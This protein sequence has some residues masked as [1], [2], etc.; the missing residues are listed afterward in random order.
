MWRASHF[1]RF[2]H[3]LFNTTNL[4][5]SIRFQFLP[6]TNSSLRYDLHTV[7]QKKNSYLSLWFQFPTGQGM[8]SSPRYS[9]KTVHLFS[10]NTDNSRLEKKK[11]TTAVKWKQEQK[12]VNHLLLLVFTVVDTSALPKGREREGDSRW[13]FVLKLASSQLRISSCQIAGMFLVGRFF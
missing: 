3:G 10:L 4:S 7:I 5:Y 12:N 9:Q 2:V 1:Q 8:G 11:K 6:V 13:Q